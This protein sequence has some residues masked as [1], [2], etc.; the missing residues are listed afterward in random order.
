MDR[1]T[2]EAGLKADGYQEI[3][4]RRME[5]GATAPE[6]THPFDARLLILEGEFVLGMDGASRRFGP[7]ETCEVPANVRHAESFGPQ[8]ATYIAGRR[9]L[10][11]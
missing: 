6:H 10:Q 9:R 4:E 7:G 1:T 5:A 2:F 3:V 11:A 8:G